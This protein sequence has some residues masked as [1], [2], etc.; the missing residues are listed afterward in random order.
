[1]PI[2]IWTPFFQLVELAVV[3]GSA[4][5][6][7]GVDPALVGGELVNLVGHL[8]GQFPGGAEDEDLDGAVG[9]VGLFDGGNGEGGG[10][11]G[12][13]LGLPHHVVP[14]EKD[15]NGGGLDGGGFLEAQRF[16][17]LENGRRDAE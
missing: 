15:G 1:V 3:G 6:G 16:D 7:H 14:F 11:A 13:G 10:F 9:C 8:G 2:T 4:V 5:D 12:S 17:G